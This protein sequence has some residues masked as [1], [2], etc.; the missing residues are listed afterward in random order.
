MYYYKQL[1]LFQ[2]AIL[3]DFARIC[4]AP[5]NQLI[6]EIPV[7]LRLWVPETPAVGSA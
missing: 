6:H 3:K 1:D 5:L 2:Q 4:E 7:A